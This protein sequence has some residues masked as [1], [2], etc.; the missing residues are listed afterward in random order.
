MISID[1]KCPN[2]NSYK[3]KSGHIDNWKLKWVTGQK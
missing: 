2:M 1:K 3:W